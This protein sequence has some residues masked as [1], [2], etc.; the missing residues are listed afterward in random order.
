MLEYRDC[1]VYGMQLLT[2]LVTHQNY[3]IVTLR[4]N[5]PNE[6]WLTNPANKKYPVIRLSSEVCTELNSMDTYLKSVHQVI[7]NA[8]GAKGDLL[9]LN[10]NKESLNLKNDFVQQIVIVPDQPFDPQLMTLFNGID[11]AC[12][13]VEN[14][15]DEFLKC[16]KRLETKA[17][18][19]AKQRRK[20]PFKELPKITMAVIAVCVIMFLLVNLLSL[21]SGELTSAAI[22]LGAY[23]KMSVVSGFEYWRLLTAGFVHADIFHLLMNMMALFNLGFYCEKRFKKSQFLL[24]L[25]AGIIGGNL[26]VFIGDANIAGLGISGGLFGLLGAYIVSLCADGSIKNRMVRVNL[27]S[28][29]MMNV[30]I[31]LLPNI[32]LMAHLGG[33]IIGGLL[34]FI[35]IDV[36]RWQTLRMHTRNAFL[37]LILGLCLL[38]PRVQRIDPFYPMTDAILITTAEKLNLDGYADYLKNNFIKTA[39]RQ[40]ESAYEPSL[41]TALLKLKEVNHEKK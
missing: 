34:A 14:N 19:E 4:Q 7:L 20:I 2:F 18:N 27:T 8:I 35:M 10:T 26:F 29:I 30:F 38:V 36:K 25:L 1:D 41:N 6:Y 37:L 23:Y 31:S 3:Q 5:Q 12:H 40:N 13:K 15:R 21:V 33:F 28:T 16:V 39:T 32:S 9:L 11:K 24:I 17:M 22:F